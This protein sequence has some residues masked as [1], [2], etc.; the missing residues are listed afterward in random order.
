MSRTFPSSL[1][2][3]SCI[4]RARF[5]SALTSSEKVHAHICVNIH[6]TT[7]LHLCREPCLG[8]FR[9]GLGISVVWSILEKMTIQPTSHV[10]PKHHP[11]TFLEV[12]QGMHTCGVVCPQKDGTLSLHLQ[13]SYIPCIEPTPWK[14]SG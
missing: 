8:I 7:E 5:T 3:Q 14:P 4:G 12:A 13:A 10:L 9:P 2:K 11:N 6:P 1:P